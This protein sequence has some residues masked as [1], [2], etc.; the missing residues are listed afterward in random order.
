M[1]N[2]CPSKFDLF[3]QKE[4]NKCTGKNFDVKS[5]KI[6]AKQESTTTSNDKVCSSAAIGYYTITTY[7]DA[8]QCENQINR[9]GE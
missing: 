3:I 1:N 6:N 5:F 7:D 4:L 9:K 2:L 8:L